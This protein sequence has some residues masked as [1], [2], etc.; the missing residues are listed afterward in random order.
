MKHGETIDASWNKRKKPA[1]DI[2]DKLKFK[3]RLVNGK[4]TLL[5][6]MNPLRNEKYMQNTMSCKFLDMEIFKNAKNEK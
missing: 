2:I 5:R 1:V 4:I 3:L 6:G